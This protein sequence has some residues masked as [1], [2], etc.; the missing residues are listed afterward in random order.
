MNDLYGMI[1]ISKQAHYKRV[2]K[3][4]RMLLLKEQ[5]IAGALDLRKDHRK[6]GCR[7]IYWELSPV[8]IGRDKV[9]KI[10]LNN[11]FRIPKRRSYTRTTFSGRSSYPN[12][13]SGIQIRATNQL[14]VS[15]ITYIPSGYKTYFYLTLIQDVYNREVVGWSLSEDLTTNKT[16]FKAYQMAL[17]Q[18]GNRLPGLIFH[19]DRGT[20]YSS[21]IMKSMHRQSQVIPSMGNK[22]WENA[23]AETLNGLLKN[24]YIE[25]P[26]TGISFKKANNL[27]KHWI[28]LY[29]HKR[30]H[31]S[32]KNM[33]PSNYET[34]LE[35]L[36][37]EEKPIVKINY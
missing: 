28:Y 26:K 21:E 25:L 30:P 1:G 35:G 23:H 34:A 32:L 18:K 16:V 10:L 8:G 27:I 4:D 19:S 5:L 14:W 37:P 11:G 22:A 7:K 36:C 9:E 24:E 29:N 2:N 6:L 13:I 33:K 12:L 31:G 17:N 20:Q 3:R 15:D